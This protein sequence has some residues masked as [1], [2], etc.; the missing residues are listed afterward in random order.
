M[1]RAVV[2]GAG[3]V[4][5]VATVLALNPHGSTVAAALPATGSGSGSGSSTGSGSASGSGSGSGS[6][7]TGTRT[8]TGDAVD[9][10]Y[11]LVQVKVTLDGGTI[12]AIDAVQLPQND[13][14]SARISQQSWPMLV[15]Q[16]IAA[17]SAH[18]AGVSGAS[19]TSYG[20]V[21]S[22]TSA[23]TSLGHTA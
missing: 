2:V 20:F 8:A 21:Q 16:A 6:G 9:V 4:V 10:G 13:G 7:S 22:L 18:I 17:Q 23:L 19:Y 14:H 5:G 12:S 3:T 1:I 15:S 11:G